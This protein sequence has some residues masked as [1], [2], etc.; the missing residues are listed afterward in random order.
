MT[1]LGKEVGDLSDRCKGALLSGRFVTS[2]R[3][4]SS[5][6]DIHSRFRDR[7]GLVGTGNR[8]VRPNVHYPAFTGPKLPFR[9]VQH[10]RH[11]IRLPAEFEH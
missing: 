11:S 8:T 5:G 4:L 1:A 2:H 10:C 9:I 3:Q 7:L 6:A